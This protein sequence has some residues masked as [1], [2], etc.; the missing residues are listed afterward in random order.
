MT[1]FFDDQNPTRFREKWGVV[2]QIHNVGQFV[3]SNIIMLLVK[4]GHDVALVLSKGLYNIEPI[5]L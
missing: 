1:A 3:I 5:G 4:H 2:E